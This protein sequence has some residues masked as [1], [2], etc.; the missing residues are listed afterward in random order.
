M[1]PQIKRLLAEN[2]H[3]QSG[4]LALLTGMKPRAINKFKKENGL[5]GKWT[6]SGVGIPFM[7]YEFSYLVRYKQ[8]HIGSSG[9]LE[10]AIDLVDH[11]IWCIENNMFNK[12]KIEHPYL[13]NLK[14]GG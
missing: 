14:L 3:L 11:L 4:K 9:L 12:P 13:S 8:K 1:T 10:K 7:C 5:T 6:Y 2:P